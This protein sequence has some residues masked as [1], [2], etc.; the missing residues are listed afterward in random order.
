MWKVF[1]VRMLVVLALL[2]WASRASAESFKVVVRDALSGKPQLGAEVLY[3][4][5]G[6]PPESLNGPQKTVLT[7]SFGV[8][9]IPFLCGEGDRVEISVTTSYRKEECGGLEPKTLKEIRTT[10]VISAPNGEGSIWCPTRVSRKLTPVPGEV[11]I[12]VKKP[13]WWQAHVAG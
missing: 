5:E 10:G 11:L 12:F 2:S 1:S 7:D 9:E 3:F 13:T 6:H 8:V 4:C